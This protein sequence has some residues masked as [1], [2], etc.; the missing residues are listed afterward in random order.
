MKP[1]KFTTKALG[2]PL[3]RAHQGGEERIVPPLLPFFGFFSKS[4]DFFMACLY[5]ESGKGFPKLQVSGK[6]PEPF[7]KAGFFVSG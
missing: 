1:G 5:I 3:V 2:E 4:L 6:P 7:I